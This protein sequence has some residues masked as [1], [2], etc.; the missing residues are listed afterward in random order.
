[1]A[2]FRTR[3][4]KIS[5]S[6]APDVLDITS[7]IAG[8]MGINRSAF[9]EFAL[10][11]FIDYLGTGRRRTTLPTLMAQRIARRGIQISRRA[12]QKRRQG[13]AWKVHRQAAPPS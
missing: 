6:I 1:M 10:M 7:E 8:L 13:L 3:R 11:H 9:I 2:M 4:R 12:S 5:H